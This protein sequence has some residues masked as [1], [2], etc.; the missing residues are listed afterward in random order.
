MR[1]A[2]IG[3]A[4]RTGVGVLAACWCVVPIV[5][6]LGF[7]W[8]STFVVNAPLSIVFGVVAVAATAAVFRF[9]AVLCGK[10]QARRERRATG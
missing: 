6:I 1:S 3:S 7:L 4:M 8:I 9:G 2:A 10:C 5:V